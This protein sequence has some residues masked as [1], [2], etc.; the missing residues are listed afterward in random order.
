MSSFSMKRSYFFSVLPG[1]EDFKWFYALLHK[2]GTFSL[3]Q[4]GAA[5]AKHKGWS[6]NTIS[7]MTKVFLDLEFVK[8]VD[9]VI[10]IQ[11]NVVKKELH[12]SKTYQIKQ[13]EI[14][15]EQEL[16]Y[17]SFSEMIMTLEKLIDHSY[18]LEEAY[19]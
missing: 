17:S 11:P 8:I 4:Q 7:F 13:E 1:R 14:Q 5:L 10:H 12:Q 3:Q 18:Q 2:K 19:A 9:G 6:M 16:I 15:L